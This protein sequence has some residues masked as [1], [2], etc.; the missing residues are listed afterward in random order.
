MGKYQVLVLFG[1]S[2]AGKSTIMHH[3]MEKFPGKFSFSISHTTR[4]P[5]GKEQN[6]VDYYFIEEE[7]MKKM[8]EEDKFIEHA[9][10]HTAFYG[11][12]KMEIERIANNNQIAIL[13]ID[14]QGSRQI[15]GKVAAFFLFI[16]PPSMEILEQRLRSRGTETEEQV[17][18]RL[19]N[20]LIEME[21]EKEADAV[22]VNNVFTEGYGKIDELIE[23]NLF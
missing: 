16:A 3:L 1:P 7:E 8:I 13:D 17:Q 11:T 10:V 23:K 5:R 18:V 15:R 19:K 12:S 6:G 9:H 20:A 14:L 22:V 4:K 2:G 21:G